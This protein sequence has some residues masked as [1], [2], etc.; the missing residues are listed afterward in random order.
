MTAEGLTAEAR[1][2]FVNQGRAENIGV[3]EA[4]NLV[5]KPQRQIHAISDGTG[6]KGGAR[7]RYT[8]I[9]VLAWSIDPFR[10]EFALFARLMIEL[11]RDVIR[12]LAAT[13]SSQKVVADLVPVLSHGTVAQRVVVVGQREGLHEEIANRVKPALR[14]LRGEVAGGLSRF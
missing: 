5:G 9:L 11:Q 2:K 14:D 4:R 12:V 8:V 10:E 1:A 13:Q 6:R 3:S 7:P